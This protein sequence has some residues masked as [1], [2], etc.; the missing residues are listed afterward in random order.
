MDTFPLPYRRLLQ[1]NQG[2][3]LIFDQCFR[4][5]PSGQLPYIYQPFLS[6]YT[7][8]CVGYPPGIGKGSSG[9]LSTVLEIRLSIRQGDLD[10]TVGHKHPELLP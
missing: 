3:V 10:Y 2:G 9:P 5:P 7:I 1:P 6:V 8:V 4:L